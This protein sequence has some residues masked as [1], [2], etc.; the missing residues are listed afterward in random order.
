MLWSIFACKIFSSGFHSFTL[1]LQMQFF[2]GGH[3]AQW[4][5]GIYAY[6]DHQTT[7]PAENMVFPVPFIFAGVKK[8]PQREQTILSQFLHHLSQVPQIL[9]QNG[10]LLLF[11]CTASKERSRCKKWQR[12]LFLEKRQTP[13]QRAKKRDQGGQWVFAIKRSLV[14]VPSQWN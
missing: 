13:G 9:Q 14:W 12:S 6:V 11:W 3:V 2:W 4:I 7:L 10:K 8:W 5:H 1:S